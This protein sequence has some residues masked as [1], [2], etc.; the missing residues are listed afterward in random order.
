MPHSRFKYIIWI[1]IALLCFWVISAALQWQQLSL[2]SGLEIKIT[3][4]EGNFFIDKSDIENMIRGQVVGRAIN[5][6]VQ[7]LDLQKLE[8]HIRQNPYVQ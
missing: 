1:A 7:E 5:I 8:D 2:C 4:D 3:Y 6:P